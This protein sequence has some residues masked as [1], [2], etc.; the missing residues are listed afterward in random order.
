MRKII[1]T[2]LILVI[3]SSLCICVY[4]QDLTGLQEQSSEITEALNETNNRLQAVQEELSTNMQQLQD[5]DNQIAQSQEELSTINTDIDKLMEQIKENEEKLAKTQ[6]EYDN[7]QGLLDARLI[8]MYEAPEFQFLQVLLEAKNV[9][10]FLSTY[11]AMKELAEYDAELLDTVKKQKQDIETTKQILA[12]KKQQV[13]TSKQT[14]AKKTQVLANTK[15][16]R[17]YYISKLSTEEQELQAK[18]DEYNNQV[19]SIEAEIKL[20]ALNSISEDYIGGAMIWPVPGY[21]SITSEYGMR[22]H[23]ITGAYKLH[24]GVDIG[25]P[26]GANFV[27]AANGIVSKATFNAAYG[28]MVIIDHGGGVQTLYAH[29]SEILVQV[30]QTVEAGTPI[31]KV[32]STGYS[33]GPHAHFEIRID[34]QTINPLD[35]LLKDDIKTNDTNE[36]TADTSENN[37]DETNTNNN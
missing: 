24:T 3:I 7:I 29:G 1:S 13:I 20:L 18:I 23:P 36:N 16:M 19:A 17:E 25:A 30:G 21:T 34:G 14:L 11:Y 5:L 10:D 32:G 4:A 33:T 27:A 8:Q 22:V 35:Y 2:I 12:Q 9:T 31:L 6:K 15:T 28:N 37:I 26:L